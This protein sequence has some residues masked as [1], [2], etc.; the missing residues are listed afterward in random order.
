MQ[1]TRLIPFVALWLLFLTLLEPAVLACSC[2]TDEG[3]TILSYRKHVARIFAG[4]V[5][6]IEHTGRQ[7]QVAFSVHEV[8]KGHADTTVLVM[9]PD[10]ED[11]CGYTFLRGHQYLV[12]VEQVG[13][14]LHT[15]LC[16]PNSSLKSAGES[17]R[18]LG[19]GA[20]PSRGKPN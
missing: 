16:L 11:S 8:W 10:S 3:V 5:T 13:E 12:V 6:S 17:L 14:E 18:L 4:T 20:R 9:T 7:F 1:R 2:V 19:K 15:H